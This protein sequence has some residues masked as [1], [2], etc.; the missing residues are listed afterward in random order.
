MLSAAR[1]ISYF[2]AEGND[3]IDVDQDGTPDFCD[4]LVDSDGD[5]IDDAIDV[6]PSDNTEW[7]DSDG[8]GVGNNADAYP[9]DPSRNVTEEQNTN[10]PVQEN[11]DTEDDSG[12]MESSDTQSWSEFLADKGLDSTMTMQII[13]VIFLLMLVKLSLSS[14]KIKKLKQKIEKISQS[15]SNWESLDLDEDGELSDLEFEAYKLIRDKDK[16][17]QDESN[18]RSDSDE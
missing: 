3:S 9:A 2:C 5:G 7:V 18:I 16:N 10:Q 4:L 11:T 13:A 12:A 8:D 17:P 1:N 15:K 14:R 6:F